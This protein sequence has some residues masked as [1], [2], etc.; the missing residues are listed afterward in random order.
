MV[1]FAV[2]F[3]CLSF[4][5][6]F[7]EKLL[8]RF[9]VLDSTS[10]HNEMVQ[11]GLERIVIN[12]VPC[13]HDNPLGFT[14]STQFGQERKAVPEH[15]GRPGRQGRSNQGEGI[16]AGETLGIGKV[17]AEDAA[18]ELVRA[19]EASEIRDG[20]KRQDLVKQ[21]IGRNVGAQRTGAGGGRDAL[22]RCRRRILEKTGNQGRDWLGGTVDL[23]GLW[24][25]AERILR[26]MQAA[27]AASGHRV[28]EEGMVHGPPARS[29]GALDPAH[30]L[31]PPA[32]APGGSLC[33]CRRG[34]LGGRRRG[35]PS[36]GGQHG[37]DGL[38]GQDEPP[39]LVGRQR[40]HLAA[41]VPQVVVF[42]LHGRA[43]TRPVCG[44]R[45]PVSGYCAAWTLRG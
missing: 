2:P 33:R 39:A 11:L 8:S 10:F 43:K 27:K 45:E 6:R 31:A 37:G 40:A 16:E 18:V 22:G 30:T 44:F 13:I 35:T 20:H 19:E 9:A 28:E 32:F 3:L 4:C 29:A 7:K 17:G 23:G 36:S 1:V 25:L 24:L 5:V 21:D 14:V 42:V 12:Q 15:R 26:V 34:S 41:A 38:L